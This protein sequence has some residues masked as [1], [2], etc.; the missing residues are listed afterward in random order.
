MAKITMGLGVVSFSECTIPSELISLQ[1]Q[2]Y[3]CS[4][5]IGAY[6]THVS[7]LFPVSTVSFVAANHAVILLSSVCSRERL[8]RTRKKRKTSYN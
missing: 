4:L 1:L 8:R 7:P 3:H 6:M 2:L 5:E